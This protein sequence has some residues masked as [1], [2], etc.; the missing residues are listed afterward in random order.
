MTG[1]TEKLFMCQMFMCLF[2]PLVGAKSFTHNINY[3]RIDFEMT[4]KLTQINDLV[5]I[6]CVITIV[7]GTRVF[8][9]PCDSI[10]ATNTNNS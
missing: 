3:L 9:K 2:R 5:I 10:L 1:V 4:Q 7:A 8:Q 6:I